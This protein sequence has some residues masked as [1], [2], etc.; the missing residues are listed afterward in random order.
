MLVEPGRQNAPGVQKLQGEPFTAEKLPSGQMEH[1]E[2]PAAEPEPAV[3][4]AQAAMLC[5]LSS[6]L[7]VP[8]AH[9]VGAAPA[10]QK[11]PAGHG[12]VLLYDPARHMMP[13]L[14]GMGATP[15]GQ[16][17]P[18]GHGTVLTALLR[19]AQLMPGAQGAQA[20]V[21]TE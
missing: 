10:A 16:Y 8:A 12:V 9:C 3:Q 2:E 14:Q 4:L 13:A 6:G 21:D 19:P 18:G 20:R 15:P 11:L 5:W 7:K 17:E 1:A